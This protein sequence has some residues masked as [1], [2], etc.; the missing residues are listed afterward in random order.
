MKTGTHRLVRPLCCL[1]LEFGTISNLKGT[2]GA[3]RKEVGDLLPRQALVFLQVYEQLII[4]GCELEFGSPRPGCWLWHSFLSHNTRGT[5]SQI[6]VATHQFRRRSR[7]W[8]TV[9]M[10]GRVGRP[11]RSLGIRG[12]KRGLLHRI[13]VSLFKVRHAVD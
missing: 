9:M 3:P 12:T 1:G 8:E 5:S 6:I 10:M 13:H 11:S 4:L 2:A 7:I